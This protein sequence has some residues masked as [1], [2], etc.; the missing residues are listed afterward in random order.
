MKK[1]YNFTCYTLSNFNIKKPINFW[2]IFNLEYLSLRLVY[3]LY[4]GKYT[5]PPRRG[6]GGLQ[7]S[8]PLNWMVSF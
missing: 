8:T 3:T 6:E 1:S 5:E 2:F 4:P 7:V